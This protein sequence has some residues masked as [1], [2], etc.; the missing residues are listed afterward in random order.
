MSAVSTSNYN[1]TLPEYNTKSIGYL[2]LQ[3]SSEGS[4]VKLSKLITSHPSEGKIAAETLQCC[5]PTTPAY[6]TPLHYAITKAQWAAAAFLLNLDVSW[7]VKCITTKGVEGNT[8]AEMLNTKANGLVFLLEALKNTTEPVN[9]EA[10]IKF[11]TLSNIST[12]RRFEVVKNYPLRRDF[13]KKVRPDEA[14][15]I[16]ASLLIGSQTWEGMYTEFTNRFINTAKEADYFDREG[17]MCCNQFLL[18]ASFLTGLKSMPFIMDAAVGNIPIP[19]PEMIKKF[20]RATTNKE[21]TTLKAPINYKA[22]ENLG[23]IR[24]NSSLLNLNE[25]VDR[26]KIRVFYGV[27]KNQYVDHFGLIAFIPNHNPQVIQLT[28]ITKKV[29]CEPANKAFCNQIAANWDKIYISMLPWHKE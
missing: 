27:E 23:L 1:K 5:H 2:M 25:K 12:D 11:L 7:D 19:T 24:H 20:E 15:F 14:L 18:Y 6:Y 22:A 16:E 8:P 29:T 28:Q 3:A 21:R 26:L 9:S 17:T 10:L 4:L 13:C